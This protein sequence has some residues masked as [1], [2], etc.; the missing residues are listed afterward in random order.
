MH[1][2]FAVASYNPKISII[3]PA[4][5]ESAV[6]FDV[7]SE[8]K[9]V[10]DKVGDLYEILVIDDGSSDDTAIHAV[11]AGARLVRHPYNIG[12]GAAVKTGIR[13]AHGQILVMLDADGQH[14]PND[15]PRFDWKYPHKRVLLPGRFLRS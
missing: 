2:N 7:V 6:I 9:D 1:Y 4:Y 12:N 8:V 5:N 14:R 11:T 15:I 13:N 3:I 10:L